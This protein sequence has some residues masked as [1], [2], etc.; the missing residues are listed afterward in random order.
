VTTTQRP[1][2][3]APV[4]ERSRRRVEA[5]LDATERLVVEAGVEALTTRQ[6]ADAAGIPVASLYQYFADKEAVLL[7]LADRDMAEMDRQVLT[8]LAAVTGRRTLTVGLLVETAVRAFV[9]VY[10]RR[11]AFVEIYLR[12]RTN[13]ALHA[14]GRE[15]NVRVATALRDL[16]LASGLARPEFTVQAAVLA[17]EIG[18]RVFQLAYEHD[19]HGDAALVQEGIV[20]LTAYLERYAVTESV[21][22]PVTE[23]VGGPG[24]DR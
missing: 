1:V 18:D 4:Q 12:G 16:A 15:H 2:R 11:P 14:F 22:E 17:V 9:T 7:A 8:D 23:S 10:E 13:T 5:V 3:R 21:T 19:D 24:G 20:L 6:I